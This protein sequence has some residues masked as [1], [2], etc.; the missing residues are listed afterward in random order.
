M[1]AVVPGS[2]VAIRAE[3][4]AEL[5]V[6]P[7]EADGFPGWKSFTLEHPDG[8]YLDLP[9]LD[10][11]N[12]P[13][14][15]Y[16]AFK[17]L[18]SNPPD[19][20]YGSVFNTLIDQ[21]RKSTPALRFGEALHCG[22]LEP[23]GELEKRFSVKPSRAQK[24]YRD[25]ADTVPQIKEKILALGNKP[26]GS[27]KAEFI[28]QLLDLDPKAKILEVAID[29]WKRAGF[30]ELTEEQNVLLQLMMRM[31]VAHPALQNSFTGVGL[32]EVSCFWTDENDIRQRARMDRMKPK[33][34][35][36]LKSIANWIGREFHTALLREA[37][38]RQYHVQAA[39]Y[40]EARKVMRRLLAEGLIYFCSQILLTDAEIEAGNAERRKE[41]E[42]LGIEEEA[43]KPELLEVGAKRTVF[44]E[45]TA[46]EMEIAKAVIESEVWEWVWIFYKTDGA[47][48]AQPIRLDRDT[49]PFKRGLELRKEALSH[50]AH[51]R[52]LFGVEPGKM[53]IRAEPM[54]TPDDEQ[55]PAFLEAHVS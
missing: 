1:S 33:A 13:A 25:Y 21:R 55:W 7:F 9:N 30:T 22:L 2:D 5:R 28:D 3:Q 38:L 45:L 29:E 12:D 32:S 23:E 17:V 50:Y 18:N 16:S 51:Y 47:P 54:W 36:D 49:R 15:S 14:L 24:K 52:D 20:W 41:A 8:I 40:D 39:H 6:K 34:T 53:W 31:A 42:R 27:V 11:L 43:L 4:I 10:Y 46:D 19:W 35:I 37:I 26:K 44:R 48:T